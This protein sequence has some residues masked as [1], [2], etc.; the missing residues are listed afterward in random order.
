MVEYTIEVTPANCRG[1]APGVA[2]VTQVGL[3]AAVALAV[4][5]AGNKILN[6]GCE[7]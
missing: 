6:G 3:V 2:E 7:W 5:M 1:D 4:V